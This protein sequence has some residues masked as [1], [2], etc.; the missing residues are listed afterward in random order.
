MSELLIL[1]GTTE[2]EKLTFS[3]ASNSVTA[4]MA[5]FA[6]KGSDCFTLTKIA[7]NSNALAT[8]TQAAITPGT[9]PT[10]NVEAYSAAFEALEAC[11]WNVLAIDTE[12]ASI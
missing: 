4:L 6:E 10:V 11:H 5:A 1:D 2:L 3:N 8:V 7:G 12:D 9:D